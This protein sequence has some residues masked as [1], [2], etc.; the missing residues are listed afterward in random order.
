MG[1][2]LRSRHRWKSRNFDSTEIEMK[3][4][5]FFLFAI[6]VARIALATPDMALLSVPTEYWR[7]QPETPRVIREIHIESLDCFDPKIPEYRSWP[8]RFLN[9][10]HNQT[11]ESFIRRELLLK[12]G[13]YYDADLAEE[14]ERNLRR[15]GFLDNIRIEQKIVGPNQ[16]DLYVHTEDQWTTTVNISAGTSQGYHTLDFA[17]EEDNFLGEGKS[18]GVGFSQ[19]PE[20]N[21]YGLLFYDPQFLNSRWQFKSDMR[22]LSDGYR[23]IGQFIRPFYSMDVRWSYGGVW[24]QGTSTTKLYRKGK[25]VAEI[26]TDAKNGDF[27]AARS[28]GERYRKKAFGFLFST[29][30]LY[31]PNPVRIIQPDATNVKS[32]KKNLIPVDRESYQY[33][34]IFKVANQ[35]FVKQS[36]IDN[37][38]RVEDYPTG[39][40]FGT[41]VVKSE[42]L[43]PYPDYYQLHS[44]LQYTHESSP[45]NFLVLSGEFSGRRESNGDVNNLFFYG[46]GHFYMKMPEVNIGKLHFPRQTLATNLTTVLTRNIDAP[47]QI[48]L[49]ENEGLRGYTFKSFTGQNKVL[50]NI[51]D[52]I[53]TPLDFRI[54]AI[55][56]VGFLDAGYVWSS[57]ELFR[58][59]DFGVSA[60][61][62]LRI[63]LKKSQSAKV[64]RVD[65]AFPLTNASNAFGITSNKGY[66]ISISSG[67]VFSVIEHLPKIF[68]LF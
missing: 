51:E 24:D 26:D 58:F 15:L 7:D 17:V 59:S 2:I 44:I 38:G 34:A 43:N 42:N 27:F 37:F 28:W 20:R 39:L 3:K 62:G 31:Y 30:T 12:E 23:Y 35:D 60:G 61:F 53:F 32:I 64:V 47:F 9:K 22:S 48:S 56:L 16:V 40:L 45:T 66:S 14:S 49:G 52:R 5:L 68:N 6:F 50:M 46:Y 36:F 54:V 10:V 13:D 57:E 4:A 63:G 21:T 1:K 18:I 41:T 55:G 67:Q 33:G 65:L 25:A 19:D 8:F 29:E 11:S